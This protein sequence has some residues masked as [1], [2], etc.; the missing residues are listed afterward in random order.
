[1]PAARR[2]DCLAVQRDHWSSAH[3]TVYRLGQLVFRLVESAFRLL[4]ITG[5]ALVNREHLFLGLDPFA[6]GIEDRNFGLCHGP[7]LGVSEIGVGTASDVFV[8]YVPEYRKELILIRP[9]QEILGA[10]PE[11][12]PD[13]RLRSS[14]C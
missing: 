14:P 6:G 9:V 11:D 8:P 3:Q 7:I 10:A 4:G 2:V 5:A 1:M 13:A 12:R